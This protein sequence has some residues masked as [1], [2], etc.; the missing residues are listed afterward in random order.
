IGS[1]I[2]LAS[3]IVSIAKP[4]QVLVGESIYNILLSS[5]SHYDFLNNSEF[6]EINL[7]PTKWKYLSHF[8]TESMYRVY[9]YTEN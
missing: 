9:S 7:D 3:K 4:N 8:D 6:T 2:S 5:L 1:S